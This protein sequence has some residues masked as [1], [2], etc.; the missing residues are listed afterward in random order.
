MPELNRELL[1]IVGRT[2]MDCHMHV[3][4]LMRRQAGERIAMFLHELLQRYQRGGQPGLEMH[5]PMSREEVAHYLGLALETVSRGFT[6]LQDDGV[7]AVAGRAV[8]IL[9]A[10]ELRRIA[11]LPPD[12]GSEPPLARQA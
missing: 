3:D 7:I 11:L 1:Q 2:T 4:V 10:S 5:L 12:D 6:R 9:D 8:Q